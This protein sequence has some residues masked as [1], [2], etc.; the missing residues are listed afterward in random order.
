M[1]NIINT[2]KTH[3]GYSA[4]L[5]IAA[6]LIGGGFPVFHMGMD[7]VYYDAATNTITMDSPLVIIGLAMA[8]VGAL[9]ASIT[10]LKMDKKDN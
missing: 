7:K 9:L 2:I 6:G 5:A 10:A 1:A 8:A 4:S 3:K